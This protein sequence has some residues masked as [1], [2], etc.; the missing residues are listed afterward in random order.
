MQSHVMV[1]RKTRVPVL[2]RLAPVDVETE[3]MIKSMHAGLVTQIN[4]DNN[5]QAQGRVKSKRP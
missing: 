3:S 4:R 5:L 1:A 2:R